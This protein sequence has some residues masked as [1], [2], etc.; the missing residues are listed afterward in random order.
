MTVLSKCEPHVDTVSLHKLACQLLSQEPRWISQS[1]DVIIQSRDGRRLALLYQSIDSLCF[2][3]LWTPE[4]GI[5][6]LPPTSL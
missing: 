4:F 1:P 3:S 6:A 2:I 5:P